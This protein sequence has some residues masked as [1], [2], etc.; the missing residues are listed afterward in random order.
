MIGIVFGCFAV[1]YYLFRTAPAP[2]RERWMDASTDGF[3]VVRLNPEDTGIAGVLNTAFRSIER[4]Q[5]SHASKDEKRVIEASMAFVRQFVTGFV[6]TEIP[7]VFSYD[8]SAKREEWAGVVQLRNRAAWILIKVLLNAAQ[9][10]PAERVG[11]TEAYAVRVDKSTSSGVVFALSGRNVLVSNSNNLLRRAIEAERSARQGG[12][13][14]SR[15]QPYLDDLGLDTPPQGE[16]IAGVFANEQNRLDELVRLLER[17]TGAE[18]LEATFRQLLE[19][20]KL[21]PRDILALRISGDLMTA[22]AAKGEFMLYCRQSDAAKK[23]AKVV[24]QILSQAFEQIPES[25]IQRKVGVKAQG[26]T[27]VVTLELS[28]FKPPKPKATGAHKMESTTAP[29]E[30]LPDAK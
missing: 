12:Q 2:P 4:Q 3:A 15:L 18:D 6:H 10:K 27:V 13:P 17:K 1:G 16:D 11:N 21:N 25:R 9:A 19:H 29:A 5:T 14:S 24:E 8:A 28:G 23:A 22:D 7:V 20:Q 26:A 30:Q